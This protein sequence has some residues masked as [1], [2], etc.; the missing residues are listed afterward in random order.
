ME[1]IAVEP[2]R[3]VREMH[4]LV[5]TLRRRRQQLGFSHLE[6]D[7]RAGLANGHYGK[8][9]HFDKKYGRGL[10]PVTMPLVLEALGLG[11]LIV[12]T[13][14][15]RRVRA[16]EEHPT[17]MELDLEGGSIRIHSHHCYRKVA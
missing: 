1:L 3:I 16:P 12:R 14:P 9:E 7:R 4:D 10:G 15:R 11:L 5:A 8:I 13:H 6:V 17:Q 2:A